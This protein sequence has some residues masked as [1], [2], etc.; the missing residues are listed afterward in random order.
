MTYGLAVDD[1]DATWIDVFRGA[2]QT[3]RIGGWSTLPRYPLIDAALAHLE[4]QEYGLDFY[5]ADARAAV[6]VD[7]ARRLAV[8]ELRL[9][10]PQPR[11]D[12][13]VGARDRSAP[14]PRRT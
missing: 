14:R 4:I 9:V 1:V 8:G 5:I 3:S 10:L 6:R 13:T 12:D 2:R 11:A 7:A